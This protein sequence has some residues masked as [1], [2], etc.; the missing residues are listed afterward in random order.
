MET[1]FKRSE[2]IA[3]GVNIVDYPITMAC[4][5]LGCFDVE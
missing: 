4:E 3:D 5:M 1:N 2:S